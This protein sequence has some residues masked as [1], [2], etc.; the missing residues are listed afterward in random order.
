MIDVEASGFGSGSYPIEVGFVTPEGQAHCCLIRPEP[1][2]TRWD[3]KAE[4]VHHVSRH[5]LQQYGKP[6]DEVAYWLNGY[7]HGQ[8]VYT[9]GWGHDYAW[10]SLLYDA[11]GSQPT[12]RLE[13]LR[14]LLDEGDLARWH[15]TRERVQR[16]MEL[17]R[18]RASSD[19]RVLQQ[20]LLQVRR[21]R[22][23]SA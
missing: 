6:I 8:T 11:A 10:L 21:A 16:T 13:S 20:T 23:F 7:L 3:L 2:W 22:A 18:H 14:S 9:D 4:A 17:T 5:T 1:Q 19:A 12:F 15:P